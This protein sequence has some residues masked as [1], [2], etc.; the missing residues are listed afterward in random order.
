VVSYRSEY[1]N[2]LLEHG[3]F[4]EVRGEKNRLFPAAPSPDAY[5]HFWSL[6]VESIYTAYNTN[7]HNIV[8]SGLN[9]RG[10]NIIFRSKAN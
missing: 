5:N 6:H 1:F 7:I 4:V 3:L 10:F 2:Q 8:V 9:V